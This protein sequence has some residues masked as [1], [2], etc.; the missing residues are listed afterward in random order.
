MKNVDIIRDKVKDGLEISDAVYLL[1]ESQFTI[2]ESMRFLVEEY[3]I[4][5]GEAKRVVSNHPVWSD[6]VEASKP[7]QADIANIAQRSK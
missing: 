3:R 2:T 6:V 1:H 5:L 7:L 4:G